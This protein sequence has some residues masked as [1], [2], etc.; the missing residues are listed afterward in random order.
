M[1]LQQLCC[2]F[3]LSLSHKRVSLRLHKKFDKWVNDWRKDHVTNDQELACMQ[4]MTGKTE[5]IRPSK[6]T[7]EK[8]FPDCAPYYC[9]NKYKVE[10]SDHPQRPSHAD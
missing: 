4:W 2:S 10:F 5:G 1:T 7:I 6:T 3:D 9:Y 8:I